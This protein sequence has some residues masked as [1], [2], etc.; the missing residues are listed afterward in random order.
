M[1]KDSLNL[2]RVSFRK[3]T[4][5]VDDDE[6]DSL[7]RFLTILFGSF[8]NKYEEKMSNKHAIC[9]ER[10]SKQRKSAI[11]LWR[12]RRTSSDEILNKKCSN[13]SQS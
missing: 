9:S 13:W 3:K 5:V 8:R 7:A 1:A 10:S 4:F 12:K 6:E 11:I 2:L